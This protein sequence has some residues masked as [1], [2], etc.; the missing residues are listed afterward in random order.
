MQPAGVMEAATLAG[1][2]RQM[3][4]IVLEKKYLELRGKSQKFE[5]QKMIMC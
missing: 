2:I 1:L 5:W 4:K 3:E